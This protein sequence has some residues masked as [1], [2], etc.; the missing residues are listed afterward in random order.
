MSVDVAWFPD[1]GIIFPFVHL[2]NSLRLN[3]IKDLVGHFWKPM[4]AI[5]DCLPRRHCRWCGIEGGERVPTAP[6]GWY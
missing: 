2:P 1:Y 6:L 5:L 3:P 4:R